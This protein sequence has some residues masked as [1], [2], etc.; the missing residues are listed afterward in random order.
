MWISTFHAFGAR[1]LRE[2]AS[3]IGYDTFTIL[4][5]ADQLSQIK[6]VMNKLD[7]S[8]KVFEPKS[9]LEQINKAKRLC[10][11]SYK[12]EEQFPSRDKRFFKIYEQYEKDMFESKSMDFADLLYQLMLLFENSDILDK[13][14][15]QFKFINVDEYQDTNRIQYLLLKK[16]LGSNNKIFVVGDEDQSIYSW[17]GADIENILGLQE[18]FPDIEVIKLEENYRSTQTI[19]SAASSLISKN[20]IRTEK[21]IF[22]NKGIGDLISVRLLDNEYEEG[23]FVA[24]QISSLANEGFGYEDFAIFYRTHAQSRVLEEKLMQFDIPYRIVGGMRFYERKEIKDI[25]AYFRLALNP[26]D[27]VS[28]IRGIGLKRGVGSTTLD[29]LSQTALQKKSSLI[30][31]SLYCIEKNLFR[32]NTINNF[33]FICF[34]NFISSRI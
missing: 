22:S 14:K 23:R 6:K 1:I 31:A 9:V 16:L 26:D 4:D 3:L 32:S 30:K 25:V 28:F 11:D 8:N 13:Y 24:S 34:F 33:N 2:H 7:I 27:D 5:K 21:S 18:D 15:N 19:V 29:R 12:F 17:R 10:L 20:T